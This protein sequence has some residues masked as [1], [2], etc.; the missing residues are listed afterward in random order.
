MSTADEAER[1]TMDGSM[2]KLDCEKKGGGE[3]L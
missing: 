3:R 2:S 1:L